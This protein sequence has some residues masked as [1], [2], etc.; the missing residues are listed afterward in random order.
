MSAIRILIVEDEPL[1]AR[2]IAMYLRT[3][4]Y[5]VSGIAHDSEEAYYQ[6]RHHRPD[7]VI[8]DINLE[9]DHD[10]VQIAEYINK[11]YFLPFI[12]LTSYSDKST[13]E[14]SKL[15]NPHGFIVKPFHEKALF[16][17]IEIALANHAAI[18]NK[19][20]P[21]LV[22]DRINPHLLSTLTEREFEVLQLLY[23]GKTNSQI[24]AEL[25]IAVNTLKKHIN[26]IYFKLEVSSRT[27]ALAKL[28][29][30]MLR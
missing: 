27:T 4:D 18:N 21:E 13:L 23:A 29:E 28:R 9:S 1:I 20:V 26:N 11:H 7:F 30:L 16:A 8:L 10:G 15:T 17:A 6:L 22:L 14:R 5:E 25:F 24:A 2:N 19:H 12:F 3:H